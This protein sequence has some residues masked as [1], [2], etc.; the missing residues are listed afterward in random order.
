MDEIRPEVHRKN[1]YKKEPLAKKVWHYQEPIDLF[2][3]IE[4]EKDGEDTGHVE[5]MVDGRLTIAI[6]R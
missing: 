2:M 4:I 1:F 5:K 3:E 6:S